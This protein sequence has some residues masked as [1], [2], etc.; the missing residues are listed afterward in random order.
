MFRR[1]YNC[2]IREN[3][4]NFKYRCQRFKRGYADIDLFSL[5]YWFCDTFVRMLKQFELN[6]HGYPCTRDFKELD[7]LSQEWKV[8]KYNEIIEELKNNEFISKDMTM[9]EILEEYPMD[10]DFIKWKMLL[11]YIIECL[12]IA[13]PDTEY[14]LESW[15]KYKALL[16]AEFDIEAKGGI[17]GPETKKKEEQLR[18]QWLDDSNK[19]AKEQQK[20]A[21]E[22][23]KLLGKYFYSL[24]D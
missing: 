8:E 18:K 1:W 9:K 6:L 21:E 4:Y 7:K 13:N 19:Y 3:Y 16:D 12:E 24:W 10:D 17:I 23:F 14:D 11:K 15:S 2:V 22:A 5:D 20:R